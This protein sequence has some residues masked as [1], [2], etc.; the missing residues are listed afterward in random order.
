MIRMKTI[1]TKEEFKEKLAY[2]NMLV[3]LIGLNIMLIAGFICLIL[4]LNGW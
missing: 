3:A 1:K 4:K 2:M